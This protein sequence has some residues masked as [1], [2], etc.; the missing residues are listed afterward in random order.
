M[1]Q[2]VSVS[3]DEAQLSVVKDIILRNKPLYKGVSHIV[4]IALANFIKNEEQR[5]KTR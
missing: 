2:V 3:I 4:T 1:R 5:E